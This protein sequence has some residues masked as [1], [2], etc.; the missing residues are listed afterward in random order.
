M[1][2]RYIMSSRIHVFSIS[3]STTGL[4]FFSVP[5]I[6][7]TFFKIFLKSQRIVQNPDDIGW[8]HACEGPCNHPECRRE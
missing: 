1:K 4:M 7:A 2:G 8:Y 6:V 3:R 5:E